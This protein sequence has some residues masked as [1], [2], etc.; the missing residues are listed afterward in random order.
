MNGRT[1]A[2][3]PLPAA[4][5]NADGALFVNAAVLRVAVVGQRRA[6]GGGS[7]GARLPCGHQVN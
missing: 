7:G 5:A 4:A 2:K 1:I 3:G 6:S